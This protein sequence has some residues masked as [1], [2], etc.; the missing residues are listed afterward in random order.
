[1]FGC[2]AAAGGLLAQNRERQQ[3]GAA[4]PGRRRT[5]AGEK[6]WGLDSAGPRLRL[7]FSTARSWYR[8][9]AVCATKVGGTQ[10]PAAGK[11]AN[12]RPGASG[13]CRS[14]PGRVQPGLA[15]G[16]LKGKVGSSC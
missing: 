6:N 2:K 8:C 16:R 14:V 1:M 9:G 4:M 7:S 3:S 11:T 12:W 15:H 13:S 10:G 5:R